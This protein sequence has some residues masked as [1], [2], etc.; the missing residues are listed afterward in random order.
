MSSLSDRL[1][2]LGV[3]TGDGEPRRTEPS[4]A[5][6]IDAVV[7]GR[8]VETEFGLAFVAEQEH[9]VDRAHGCASLRP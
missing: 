8:F 5:Q 6:A 1:R 3:P 7:P 2:A 4:T 9:P